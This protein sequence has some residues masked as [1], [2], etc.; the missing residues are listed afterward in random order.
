MTGYL[1]VAPFILGYLVFTFIPML[2]SVFISFIDYNRLAH[3]ENI[4]NGA[5]QFTGL[6]N[7]ARIFS[8]EV[9]LQA[10]FKSFLY[11]LYFVP[12]R[13]FLGLLLAIFFNRKFY[14]R[15]LSRTLVLVPYVTNI[16][17]VTII[18]AIIL[19]KNGIVNSLI[20]LFGIDPP[21]WLFNTSTVLP[22]TAFIGVWQSLALVVIVYLAALQGVPAELYEAS[23]LDGAN[24]LQDFLHITLPVISP[25]TFFLVVNNVILAFSNFA[26]I[27]N[28]TGGGPGTASRVAVINIYEEAFVFNHYSYAAAQSIVM[29][30]IILLFSAIQWKGQKRWVHY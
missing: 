10:Y 13:I 8:D 30:I 5:V 7:Y 22:V 20:R 6:K 25:T 27:K 28:L 3:L 18:F 2:F 9:A 11:I 4:L 19:D 15:K 1:F 17:A 21:M 12:L 26:L 23:S 14:L 16:V 24:G 29:F